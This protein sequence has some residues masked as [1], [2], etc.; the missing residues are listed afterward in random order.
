MNTDHGHKL[1]KE[2]VAKNSSSIDSEDVVIG[3]L[4]RK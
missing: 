1:S 4:S 2:P 3:H